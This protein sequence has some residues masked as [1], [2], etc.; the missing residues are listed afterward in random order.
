[1]HQTRLQTHP[2]TRRELGLEGV[3]EDTFYEVRES[4]A[5]YLEKFWKKFICIDS[6]DM[7]IYGDFDSS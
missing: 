1:M 3:E 7:Y 5:S 2:C 6:D 4:S